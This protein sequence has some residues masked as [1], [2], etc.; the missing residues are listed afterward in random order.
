VLASAPLAVSS[1]ALSHGTFPAS[2]WECPYVLAC[3]LVPSFFRFFPLL[4]GK[5]WESSTGHPFSAPRGT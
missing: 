5:P 3:T 2:Q 1:S 4:Y